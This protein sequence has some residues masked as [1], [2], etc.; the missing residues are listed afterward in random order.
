MSLQEYITK[1]LSI[2]PDTVKSISFSV[3]LDDRCR[4]VNHK[5]NTIEFTLI[6]E[7][8]NNEIL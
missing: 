1:V 5:A 6:L 2:M 4:I 8:E 3:N 7:K